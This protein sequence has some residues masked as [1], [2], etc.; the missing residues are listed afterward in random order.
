MA[1]KAVLL[2][3]DVP[4]TD[5]EPKLKQ[6]A[7]RPAIVFFIL[8]IVIFSFLFRFFIFTVTYFMF[9][10]RLNFIIYIQ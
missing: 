10:L 7:Q 8:F 1:A 9:I 3:S 5:I 4:D 6:S 2:L